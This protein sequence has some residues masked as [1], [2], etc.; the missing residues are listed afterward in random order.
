MLLESEA[1]MIVTHLIVRT[2][3]VVKCAYLSYLP[4]STQQ[5]HSSLPLTL[6][7]VTEAQ[8]AVFGFCDIRQFTDATEVLQ[9]GVMEFVNSI[10]HIVHAAVAARCGCQACA[11]NCVWLR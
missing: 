9:E 3:H 2:A 11:L 6:D 10:S 1:H 8:V 4:H 5:P 7:D